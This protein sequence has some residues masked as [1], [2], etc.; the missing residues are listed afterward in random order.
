MFSIRKG[1]TKESDVDKL[2]NSGKNVTIDDLLKCADLSTAYRNNNPKLIGFLISEENV[3]ALL[4]LLMQ[5]DARATHK[6]IISLFQTNNTILHR[7]F[8]DS[9]SLS[10]YA[11]RSLE[12]KYTKNG[13]YAAGT[14]SRILSRAMDMWAV[15]T[16]QV[17]QSSDSL[18]YV[19]ISN[20]EQSCIYYTIQDLITSDTHQLDL[21]I[22]CL[23]RS[24][25]GKEFIEKELKG[26]K[27]RTCFL[28]D[29]EY[30][31]PDF[32]EKCK[33][34][35]D[36]PEKSI[37]NMKMTKSLE[38]L[39]A[40][41][42]KKKTDHKYNDFRQFI[43][44][45][46]AYIFDKDDFI[47]FHL[48]LAREA[49]KNDEIRTKVITKLQSLVEAQAT[50]EE[51]NDADNLF[52]DRCLSYLTKFTD[53]ISIDDFLKITISLLDERFTQ[54]TLLNVVEFV[55][56]FFLK[57][58]E[59]LSEARETIDK[60]IIYSW[61]V[62]ISE[63]EEALKSAKSASENRPESECLLLQS[64]I[65]DLW[66]AA[67]L[68]SIQTQSSKEAQY[69]DDFQKVDDDDNQDF[70]KS[71]YSG[72][73]GGNNDDEDNGEEK[74]N[75]EMIDKTVT[76]WLSSEIA[77]QNDRFANDIKVWFNPEY[78]T[79]VN[80]TEPYNNEIN[81]TSRFSNVSQEV[82]ENVNN[83]RWG[84]KFPVIDS[85][86]PKPEQESKPEHEQEPKPEP[87]QESNQEP[88]QEPEQEQGDKIIETVD[89]QES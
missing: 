65:L 11:F 38:L 23:F 58:R 52:I 80:D 56:R 49:G 84:K 37:F 2:F 14:I 39:H 72:Y 30:E 24:I 83:Y 57:E 89:E 47:P 71:Q 36:E 3:K 32:H 16:H 6:T 17:F 5:S 28:V 1:Q 22:W 8:A 29:K 20:I 9:K 85:P 51:V 34:S 21:F 50:V 18:Y 4:D 48:E 45:Y 73:G 35:K 82:M 43:L 81:L 60:L 27:P 88:G 46:I 31:L 63:D 75:S 53:F 33:E 40:Y 15:E 12:K 69:A 59:N 68:P 70:M 62:F 42:K 79:S 26:K 44:K 61:N 10:E 67:H 25:A 86:E 41:L 19:I 87:E 55:R 77:S 13:C 54:F 78:L 66:K 76:E 64:I 7:F 74:Q